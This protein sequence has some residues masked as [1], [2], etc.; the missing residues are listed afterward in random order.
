MTDTQRRV[1]RMVRRAVV[2]AALAGSAF[3]GFQ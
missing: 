2:F 1:L 3:T